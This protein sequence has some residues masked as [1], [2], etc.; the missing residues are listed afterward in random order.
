MTDNLTTSRYKTLAFRYLGFLEISF[1]YMT[2]NCVQNMIYTKPYY[3]KAIL[4]KLCILHNVGF[5][6]SGFLT[7]RVAC[8]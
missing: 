7:Q 8:A 5:L 1:D 2:I 6:G 4:V 3:N